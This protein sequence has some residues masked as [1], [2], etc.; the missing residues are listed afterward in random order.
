MLERRSLARVVMS[1]SR[2]FVV[3]ASAALA[4]CAALLGVDHYEAVD[5]VGAACDP[6]QDSGGA[7]GS[8]LAD[9]AGLAIDAGTGGGGSTDG[10]PCGAL[11]ACTSG[12]RVVVVFLQATSPSDGGVPSIVSD[13][14]GIDIRA[15]ETG[16]SCF[17]SGNRV[18]LEVRGGRADFAGVSCED[19]TPTSECRFYVREPRCIVATPR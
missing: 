17:G 4:G 5:C 3:A 1:P 6:T 14:R 16:S 9:A 15:G 10:G 12:H 18:D 13:P 8:V 11:L 19:S 2:A 7:D